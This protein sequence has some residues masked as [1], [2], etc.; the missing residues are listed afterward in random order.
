MKL[1][2]EE[3][4]AAPNFLQQ[5]FCKSESGETLLILEGSQGSIDC[6]AMEL[7]DLEPSNEDDV[8]AYANHL[9]GDRFENYK[10]ISA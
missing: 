5:I 4:Q 1:I 6:R 10:W 3:V 7:A 9:L 2:L 8:F